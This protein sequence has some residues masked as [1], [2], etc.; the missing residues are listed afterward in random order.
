MAKK[1]VTPE[2]SDERAREAARIAAEQFTIHDLPTILASKTES[3][4]NRLAA[5]KAAKETVSHGLRDPKEGDVPQKQNVTISINIG[6]PKPIVL[7]GS[8]DVPKVIEHDPE[9]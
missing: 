4:S 3:T 1:K 6:K 7:T 5:Y 8:V 2:V 9:E